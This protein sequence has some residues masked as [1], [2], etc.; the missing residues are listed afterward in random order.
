MH[1]LTPLLSELFVELLVGSVTQRSTTAFPGIFW[2]IPRLQ[3]EQGPLAG[4]AE[5]NRSAFYYPL[6]AFPR[7]PALPARGLQRTCTDARAGMVNRAL[8]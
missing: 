1:E 3:L 2:A 8:L 7:I 5:Q 4:H 6:N